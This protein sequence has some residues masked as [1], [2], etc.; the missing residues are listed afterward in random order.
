MTDLNITTLINAL[1]VYGLNITFKTSME[2]W[3]KN[4]T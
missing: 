1:N 3:M 4:N 2:D